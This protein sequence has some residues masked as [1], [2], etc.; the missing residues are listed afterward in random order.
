[1][2]ERSQSSLI[3]F[4]LVFAIIMTLLVVLQVTAVP[5]WNQG[6][7][8]SHNERVQDDMESVREDVLRTSA[9][10]NPTSRSVS[11]G[12]RYPVRPFLV[13]PPPPTGRIET[14]DPGQV[15]ITNA[16]APG[17]TG[18]YW[19]RSTRAFPDRAL[20]YEP[21]YNE[22]DNAPATVLE[23]AVLYNRFGERHLPRTE[24]Q[25]VSGRRIN[26]VTLNGT[27]SRG[28]TGSENLELRPLSAPQQVTTVR[29]EGPLVLT[30]PTRL[31]EQQW[32]ELLAE[33]RDE[34][35]GRVT[36]ISVTSGD[37]GAL[38]LT[39]AAGESYDLRMAKVGL[40]SETVDPGPYYIT[41]ESPPEQRLTVGDSRRVVFEVRDR[42]NNPVSGVDVNVSDPARGALTPVE[43]VS[44][45]G[46]RAVFR[47]DA[48][49]PGTATVEAS[50][51]TGTVG[52]Q[53]ANV[54]LTVDEPTAT[55]RPLSLA[56]TEP[57][58]GNGQ[59]PLDAGSGGAVELTATVTPGVEGLGVQYLLS[60][61]TVGTLDSATGTTG[62]DGRATVTFTPTRDGTV[63]VYAIGAGSVDVLTVTVT[64]AS[65]AGTPTAEFSV[66][67]TE[68][69]PGETVTFD[70]TAS[71][72]PDGTVESYE[73]N[74]GDGATES[75]PVPTHAYSEPGTYVVTL[76]V[77][78][79][80][81]ETAT[82]TRTVTTDPVPSID[83][84]AVTGESQTRGKSDIR[85]AQ[86][87]IDYAVSDDIELD[88]LRLSVVRVS[89]GARVAGRTIEL[90]GTRAEGTGEVEEK[91]RKTSLVDDEYRITVT[92]VDTDG[93]SAT[94]TETVRVRAP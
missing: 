34:A 2:S 67:P 73:W 43:P 4:V 82:T 74:F 41:T 56:W 26:I 58:G 76:T 54:T 64:N 22:Y 72:T 3:G 57:V 50:F 16:T 48:L 80:N 6:I 18:D 87:S 14:T 83:S 36:N 35:G 62:P 24:T 37:P 69:T 88:S 63:D 33:E 31:P 79:S 25:L 85:S 44:D 61:G 27:L 12:T 1:M 55:D 42:Y 71:T 29:S 92:V 5:V 90:S 17:E 52:R 47:Y 81:G 66:D 10:G 78:D 40:G 86:F 89:D 8:V 68:P 49:A 19:N 38:R 45:A 94:R 53:R 60:D 30:L 11:L 93:K 23:S 7:E 59:Y 46:G 84:L 39:L 75:G 32:R 70:G 65:G 51:G 28:G 9:T 13:N 77:T 21:D 91:N 15:R 20:V